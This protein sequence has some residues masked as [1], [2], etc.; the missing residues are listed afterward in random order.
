MTAYIR[1]LQS[2]EG[3]TIYPRT[4]ISAVQ[5]GNGKTAQQ[6]IGD[7]QDKILTFTNSSASSWSANDT[8]PDYAFRC[9]I[10]LTGVTANDYANI[11]FGM[12]E[13]TSGDYAPLCE[14]Y[15]GGVYIWSKKNTAITIPVITV[16]KG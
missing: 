1:T 14:T 9:S 13:A 4:L 5:D 8:Y 15:A 10:A 7:K 6:I 2:Q 12:T 3:D 11:I 16:L